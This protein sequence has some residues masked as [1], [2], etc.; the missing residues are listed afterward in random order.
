MTARFLALATLVL[1]CGLIAPGTATAQDDL[2]GT[3]SITSFEQGG[4]REPAE[5]QV[6]AFGDGKYRL[7]VKTQEL[8]AGSYKLDP[9]KSP[10]QVDFKIE[11]GEGMGET[12]VAIYKVD[13]ETLTM[14]LAM[15]GAKERPTT[16]TPKAADKQILM[17]LK[18]EKL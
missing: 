18:R 9:A 17:V 4:Q 7:T 6:V 1:G 16:F 13:G 11:K 12:Q 3:W 2:K 8:E 15:P 14:C 10:R 5:G